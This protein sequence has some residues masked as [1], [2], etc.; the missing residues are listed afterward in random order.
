M[1]SVNN[2]LA[3]RNTAQSLGQYNTY[4]SVWRRPLHIIEIN[5][6]KYI[7][8][9]A[10]FGSVRLVQQQRCGRLSWLPVSFILH[11]KYT[12]SFTIRGGSS[13]PLRISIRYRYLWTPKN[14]WYRYVVGASFRGWGGSLDRQG[15]AIHFFHVN[16]NCDVTWKTSEAIYCCADLYSLYDWIEYSALEDSAYSFCAKFVQLI[17]RKIIKIVAIRCQIL[18]PKCTKFDFRWGSVPNPAGGAYS[19]PQAP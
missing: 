5:S 13:L 14:R 4:D 6:L 2:N 16:L 18:R 7:Y 19:A 10:L 1:C 9:S 12:L 3:R 17:L 8:L 11:V 15:F